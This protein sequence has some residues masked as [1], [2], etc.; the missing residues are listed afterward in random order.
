MFVSGLG[1]WAD[2]PEGAEVARCVIEMVNNISVG[3]LGVVGGGPTIQAPS[4]RK[5]QI[6]LEAGSG[7][8]GSY[9]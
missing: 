9:K 5:F 4:L 2:R 8:W 6:G 1:F 3:V 7:W